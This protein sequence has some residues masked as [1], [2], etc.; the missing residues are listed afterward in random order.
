M[1]I[2][3]IMYIE[4]DKS[5]VIVCNAPEYWLTPAHRINAM[6]DS[7][8][9]YVDTQNSAAKNQTILVCPNSTNYHSIVWSN[10]LHSCIPV[11]VS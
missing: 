9:Y 7:E 6:I 3:I 11:A 1:R 10:W 5:F 4:G 8:I 2:I